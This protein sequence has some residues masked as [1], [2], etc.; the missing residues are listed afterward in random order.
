MTLKYEYVPAFPRPVRLQDC[1]IRRRQRLCEVG[2]EF[3]GGAFSRIDCV[4]RL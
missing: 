1:S 2:N 4:S 3:C